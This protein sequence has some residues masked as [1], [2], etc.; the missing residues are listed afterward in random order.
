MMRDWH[1][2]YITLMYVM[3]FVGGLCAESAGK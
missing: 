3:E 1:L 2:V